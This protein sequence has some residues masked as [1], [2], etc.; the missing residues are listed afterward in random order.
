MKAQLLACALAAAV[1]MARGD[2][3]AGQAN[4]KGKAMEGTWACV[5]ATVDGNPLPQD[6]VKQLRLTLTSNRYKT[7]KGSQ[8]LFD[9]DYTVDLSQNP[10][11]INIVGTEGD[12]KGK[13]AQGIY[14]LAGGELKICYTMPGKPRPTSFESQPGS[15]AYFIVW[16][17][18]PP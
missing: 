14:L 9:S 11:Q 1:T 7:E 18:P 2:G 4:E 3:V 8:V 12:F 13:K 6:T 15:G 16:R 5:S 10:P 17:R